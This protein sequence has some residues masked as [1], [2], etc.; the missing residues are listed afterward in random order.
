MPI[1]RPMPFLKWLIPFISKLEII[2]RYWLLADN[3]CTC[4]NKYMVLLLLFWLLGVGWQ[5][6]AS[7]IPCE[8]LPEHD[9][10]QAFHLHN[11]DETWRWLEPDPVQPLGLH[12][13]SVRHQLHRDAPRTGLCCLALVTCHR[14]F[15]I[16]CF[17]GCQTQFLRATAVPAGT[18]E[19]AY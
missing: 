6:R 2:G 5:E 1:N 19:S 18:A 8:Q 9:A 17:N 13:A 4:R 3:W 7:A 15:I 10:C 16:P 14:H 11:A 12:A